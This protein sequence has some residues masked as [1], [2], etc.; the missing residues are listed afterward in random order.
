MP[1]RPIIT[2]PPIPHKFIINKI[3]LLTSE[4]DIEKCRK[5]IEK[6]LR[7]VL[8]DPSIVVETALGDAS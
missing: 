5:F 4:E 1:K 6:E 3:S 8:H 2:D 7:V